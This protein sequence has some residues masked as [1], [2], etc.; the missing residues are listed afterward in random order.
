M[1]QRQGKSPHWNLVVPVAQPAE[2][3]ETTDDD[4]MVM[5]TKNIQIDTMPMTSYNSY[6]GGPVTGG[7]GSGLG[8]VP[9]GYAAIPTSDPRGGVTRAPAPAPNSYENYGYNNLAY[10]YW[11]SAFTNN[12]QVGAG[13]IDARYWGRV[14]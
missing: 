11:P 10:V 1:A 7:F 5:D 4:A 6:W 12:Y 13:A 9:Y 8:C 2:S 14:Y 3:T